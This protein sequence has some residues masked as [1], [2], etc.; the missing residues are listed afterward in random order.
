M[1]VLKPKKKSKKE[2]LLYDFKDMFAWQEKND[3]NDY[4]GNYYKGLGGWKDEDLRALFKQKGLDSFI[5]PFSYEEDIDELFDSWFN[6]D[7]SDFRK[8]QIREIQFNIEKA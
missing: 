8:D 1:M 5:I 6:K 7:E 4:V 2:V 3:I